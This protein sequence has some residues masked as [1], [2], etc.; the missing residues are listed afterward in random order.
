MA[1]PEPFDAKKFLS[2]V[3]RSCGVYVMKGEDDAVL[4]VGKAKNLRNRLSSHL[5]PSR[6]S[7]RF[8][9]VMRQLHCIETIVTGTETEALLLENNLIKSFRPRYN[10]DLRDDKSYPFIRLDTAHEFPGLKFYR[11]SRKEPGKYFGPFSSAAAVRHT[12]SQMQKIFPIRQCRD[13]FFRH[14]SRPCLQYQIHRCSG[15]CVDLI[16]RD[17]YMEDV[18]Q[19]VDFLSGKNDR[20]QQLLITRMDEAAAR[21]EFETAAKY[22]DRITAVQRLRESQNVEGGDGDMDVIAIEQEDGL[23]CVQVVAI[24]SGRNVDYRTFFPNLKVEVPE[25]EMLR[26]FVPQYYLSRHTPPLVLVDREFPEMEV[27]AEALR[28]QSGRAVKIRQPKRGAKKKLLE[29]AKLNARDAVRRKAGEKHAQGMRMDALARTL[30][31]DDPPSRIE[32]FDISHTGGDKTVASCVVFDG[33]GPVR[34]EY[35]RLNV[36]GIE[37]GDDYAAMRQALHRR[38]HKI[39]SAEAGMPDLVLVDGGKGQLAAAASVF[40]ELQID[41]VQLAAISK[42]RERKAGEEQLWVVNREEPVSMEADALLAL[43]RVRDEAHRF[44][45]LGHRRRRAKG[46]VKSALEQIPGIGQKRRTALLRHFGGMQGV[47]RAGVAELAGVQGISPELADRIYHAF[48][49]SE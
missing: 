49:A 9:A 36:S 15:P 23:T 17:A 24:R 10:I 45:L 21:Q 13:S 37:S 28:E 19:A 34:S 2:T 11:G 31:W 7:H 5:R 3:S 44:A 35:R 42:G 8:E 39:K 22:R 41:G 16:D 20:L 40:E 32:C 12:L 38:Y 46:Q 29:M 48:H 1:K 47:A 43:Q 14:R 33:D 26:E 4:Y 25:D 6:L 18:E 30:G 27:I